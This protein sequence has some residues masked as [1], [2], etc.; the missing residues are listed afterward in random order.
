[1]TPTPEALDRMAAETA[2]KILQYAQD[3][4]NKMDR[5][6]QGVHMDL[7]GIIRTL[8]DTVVAQCGEDGRRLDWLEEVS[9]QEFPGKVWAEWDC[10]RDDS[11]RQAI[12]AARNQQPT[13]P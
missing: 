12:D 8:L 10:L 3:N 9:Q 2:E 6:A 11:L 4:Q 5:T 1:M 13:T 7:S